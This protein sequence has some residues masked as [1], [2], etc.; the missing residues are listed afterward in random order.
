[1]ATLSGNNCTIL[2]I[3]PMEVECKITNASSPTST[4]GV[5]QVQILGGTAPY[6]IQWTN[7]Q[8]G[9]TITNLLPGTYSAVVTDYYGDYT[10]TTSCVVGSS[11]NTV[12]KFTTC[13]GLSSR[14]VYVS[15][16]TYDPPFPNFK[17]A[18]LFN[19]IPGCY[20]FIGPV[21]SAGLEVSALTISN[22]YSTCSAC[23]PPTPTPVPQTTLCLTNNGLQLQYEFTANGTD[24]NGN[25]QWINSANGLTMTYNLT[26]GSWE[27]T[28]WSNVG[29]GNMVFPQ[30][31]PQPQPI[32]AGWTNNGGNQK[33]P[34]QVQ[35]GA[36][37]GFPLSLNLNLT[38]PQ[39]QGEIGSVLM[40]ATNGVPP[41]NY[42]IQGF[43]DFQ[44]SGVFSNV[45][46]GTYTA[47]VED[48]DSPTNQDSVNF[49]INT[50][51]ASTTYDLFLTKSNIVTT[52]NMIQNS[53]TVSY[54]YS[55]YVN[56]S[57]PP[58][59]TVSFNLSFNHTEE[60]QVPVN[61]QSVNF[62]TLIVGNV[63]GIPI[64]YNQTSPQT[65]G[66]Q[67][68]STRPTQVGDITTYTTTSQQLSLT[69]NSILSGTIT[70]S[71]DLNQTSTSCTCPTIGT[72]QVTTVGDNVS[73]SG[74]NCGTIGSTKTNIITESATRSGCFTSPV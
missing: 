52:P 38:Q 57:L 35:V 36:C 65:S 31:P 18:F 25:Y 13:P 62:T 10:I 5:A 51:S 64:I 60:R 67:V 28:P 6:T 53:V 24:S 59:V 20:D 40:S 12:Y 61:G 68:C 41:Y 15:G 26:N 2:T 47:V 11:T 30:S 39:C 66:G 32:G 45:P 4:D 19:E 71:V 9:T 8:Q 44:N 22:S 55:A 7:G 73:I 27:V 37:S 14:T 54:D 23:N 33:F 3:I 16:A 21:S 1:M 49:T 72:N 17:N 74:T 50:G 56:P 34:W 42:Q 48:S 46:S 69:T 43:G 29:V 70:Q 63:D 58:G